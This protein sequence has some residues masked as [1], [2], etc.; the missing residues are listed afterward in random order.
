MAL[1]VAAAVVFLA[2]ALHYVPFD[3]P[4]YL[5]WVGIAA[6]LAGLVSLA[7]PLRFLGVRTRWHALAVALGGVGLAVAA[8]LWPAR[9]TRPAQAHGRI[10]RFLAEYQF[11][12]YHEARVRA[13]V[14]AVVAAVRQVS[15]ADMPAAVLLM[16]IRAAAGGRFRGSPPDPRPLLDTMLGPGSGFLALDLSDPSELVL[17]MVGFV[18]KPRPP[19]TTP[20]QFVAFTAPDG[21]RVAFNLRVV[22]EGGGVVRVST[23]TRSLANDDAAQRTFA[24]Y[25]RIIYPG[26]AIIRRVWLDAI[27]A[28]AARGTDAS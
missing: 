12:E 25:W 6:A 23:E 11:V 28:R 3:A 13:P 26:S 2:F 4:S 20:E 9:V 15:L 8:V 10:D 18:H 19:V 7:R 5:A 17:G 16:R 14:E 22:D 27:V 21:I 1:T 24:R